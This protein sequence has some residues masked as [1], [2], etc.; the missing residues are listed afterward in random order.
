V[1]ALDDIENNRNLSDIERVQ[2]NQARVELEK[3]LLMEE[4]CWRQ[5]SRSLWLKE[6]DK[7][8]KFFHCTTNSNH[9]KNRIGQPEV[10]RVTVMAADEIQARIVAFYNN[11]FT[12][13][14]VRRPTLDNL[15]FPAIDGAEAKCLEKAFSEEEVFEAVMNMNGDK[16]PGSDG[17]SLAFFQFCWSVLKGDIMQVFHH[18]HTHETFTKS[19][20]STF[21]A[22]IPKKP[23]AVEIKDF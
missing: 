13:S 5:K 16:A 8:T 7:N 4:I 20:N 21:I 3:T 10:D 11:L 23:G 17:F 2:C 22:L 1:K 18:F 15:P 12:E 6:G 9:R 14:R 19:I